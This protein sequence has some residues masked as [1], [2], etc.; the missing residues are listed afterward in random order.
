MI[1]LDSI[2]TGKLNLPLGGYS[3]VDTR[4]NSRAIVCRIVALRAVLFNIKPRHILSPK[5]RLLGRLFV[6]S[7]FPSHALGGLQLTGALL[8]V[9]LFISNHT[10]LQRSQQQQLMA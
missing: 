10:Q 4:L 9:A 7:L 1:L 2:V 5:K 6:A 8:P 3:G